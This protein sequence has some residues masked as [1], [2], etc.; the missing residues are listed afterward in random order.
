MRA[1]FD[2]PELLSL[3][4]FSFFVLLA[5]ARPLEWMRRLKV[6]AL[7]GA[8]VGMLF[9][10]SSLSE[11]QFVYLRT[12]PPLILIPMAYWQTAYFTTPVNR[13]L[14]QM[15]AGI[16]DWIF[17]AFESVSVSHRFRRWLMVY[18][19]AAYL[20]VYPM[21]P[22][23]LALLYFVGAIDRASEFW[24]VALP[25]AYLSYATLPFVRTLPP[26]ILEAPEEGTPRNEIQA[27]NLTLIRR[28][29]HQ[30]NTFP[31]GHSAAATAIALE[32]FRVAPAIGVVYVFV[33]ISIMLG[34]F[35]GRYHYALDLVLGAVFAGVVFVLTAL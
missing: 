3:C 17:G 19:E 5:W 15:L 11:P 25:P 27:F 18:L 4:F 16:D 28:V 26:R 20:L 21:V 2:F 12:A 14:Q 34:A 10:P 23:G 35:I 6:T 29:T 1:Q 24:T 13:D 30:S 33:A 7:G 9:L 32:M 8:A 31:S 22:S